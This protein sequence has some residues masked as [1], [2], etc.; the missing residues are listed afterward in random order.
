MTAQKDQ[1]QALIA[2]IDGVLQRTNPRLPWRVSGEAT[3]Q[4][5]VLE[6]VRNYLVSLQ[7][8]PAIAPNPGI[9]PGTDILSQDL[10]YQPSQDPTRS[11]AFENGATADATTQQLLNRVLQEISQ[12]RVSLT[13]P[14]QHPASAELI[15][16]LMNRLQEQLTQQIAQALNPAGG[17]AL[18]PRSDYMLAAGM[19]PS[20][21]SAAQYEQVQALRRRSDQIL[22]NLDATLNIVFESLQRNIQTYQDSLAQGLERMYSLG[23]QSEITFKALV[24]MLAQ[25]LQ[26]EASTYLP[27]AATEAP[28]SP[29]IPTPPEIEPATQ[30]S[31]A[32]AAASEPAIAPAHPLT[33]P[34][35]VSSFPYAGTEISTDLSQVDLTAPASL[36][37][38][39]SLQADP[40]TNAAIAAWL[41]F[42]RVQ[43][44]QTQTATTGQEPPLPDLDLSDLDLEPAPSISPTPAAAPQPDADYPPGTTRDEENSTEIDAALKLL[45]NLSAGLNTPSSVSSSQE[46]EAQLNQL[47][48]E[49]VTTGESS[50]SLSENPHDAQ[51]ELD[52]FYRLFGGSAETASELPEATSTQPEPPI[53]SNTSEETPLSSLD[54][55]GSL[56]DLFSAVKGEQEHST[57]VAPPI[58]PPPTTP[59]ADDLRFE[60]PFEQTYSELIST[61]MPP[62]E[63]PSLEQ[64]EFGLATDALEDPL[65]DQ[66]TRAAFDESLLPD[67]AVDTTSWSLELDELTL[68]SLNEDLANLESF[69]AEF[70][71]EFNP[72]P[73]IAQPEDLPPSSSTGFTLDDFAADLSPASPPSTSPPEE[74]P[75]AS[76]TAFTLDDFATTLSSTNPPSSPDSPPSSSSTAFTLDDFATTLSPS[77]PSETEI[78]PTNVT[79]PFTLEGMD[80]LFEDAPAI[81]PV[82]HQTETQFPTPGR[83]SPISEIPPFKPASVTQKPEV[84]DL[85]PFKLE[86]LDSLFT[87]VES[88]F[89]EEAMSPQPSP[90]NAPELELDEAFES[91][92]GPIASPSGADATPSTSQLDS[93]KKK[94]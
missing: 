36:S 54:Q 12:L 13:P 23:Q 7:Q 58:A 41:D 22:V 39:P 1:I 24:E 92:L 11:P 66:Y 37:A 53:P 31:D 25:Q 68:N 87:E 67:A 55:I 15:Q 75:Q 4:R 86:R 90:P 17:Q 77:V 79:S 78:Q 83:N 57:P 46:A 43:D 14:N 76:S 38:E 35:F 21:L 9:A 93:E 50:S 45:E 81:P 52:E 84:G 64:Q 42:A 8:Q 60:A 59:L 3:Q 33:P 71:I 65:E 32:A 26:Q 72:E 40:T 2:E 28:R 16:V 62:I 69:G 6:R 34:T 82:E 47:L 20:S 29:S 10:Y 63:Q 73:A 94:H 70:G 91:L 56:T 74:R 44:Q 61:E 27:P 48:G 80:D 19:P 18:A 49:P 51:D 85:P 89:T 5:Q 88:L 30:S